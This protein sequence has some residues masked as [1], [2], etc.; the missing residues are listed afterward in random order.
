MNSENSSTMGF[1]NAAAVAPRV[2]VEG[3]TQLRRSAIRTMGANERHFT[4]AHLLT[5]LQHRTVSSGLITTIAQGTQF[6]LNLG[7]IT[8]LARL[9]T[10]NDFGL[11]A[12]VTTVMG[13]LRIFKDA[14]L[15]TATVQ[16]EGITHAQVS[17]LF[18]INVAVSGAVSVLVAASAPLI[19]WFYR[20]PRIIGI[21]LALSVTFLLTGSTVQHLALL[22]RQMRFKAIACIQ[23]GSMLV[24][25]LV[26]IGMAWSGYG[27]WS[28]VGSNLAMAL[29]GCLLTWS[30]SRWRPQFPRRR[31]GTRSLV[32]FGANLAAGNFIYSLA[33]GTDGLLIGRFY[34][35]DSIG[36]YSRGAALLMRPL[37]QFF[38]T[39][40][41]VFVPALS[42]LQAEPERYR[43]AFLQVYEAIALVS[44]PLTGLFLALARPLTLVVLGPKWEKAALILA[45]FTMVALYYPLFNISSWLFATQ[46]RGRD[47][48]V[49]FCIASGVMVASFGAG[50]PFGPAGVALAYSA[51]CLLIQL[52]VRYYIAG[53][54]GP[55]STADL[56]VGF[57]RHLPLW[58]V[59]WGATGLTRASFSTSAP[60]TQLVICTPIGLLAGA[61]FVWLVDPLRHRALTLADALKRFKGANASS[62]Q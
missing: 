27:P 12:M 34:G 21:T 25:V 43:R 14:G 40:N 20:E 55:V 51:S 17:N 7:S 4:T 3:T 46:G 6:A 49:G 2:C 8:V 35:S 26:G 18:W 33:Q 53:R 60:M 48:L 30:I 58:V 59:V 50:L 41:S 39:L 9:L 31:S 10:P 45:S 56:W 29:A 11:V 47:S 57:L 37:E 32:T 16:K 5:N 28:L 24:G 42:R 1:Q 22:N 13:F 54:R 36:L 61:A 62:A 38:A 19:A 44:F 52:P 23:V 15:S